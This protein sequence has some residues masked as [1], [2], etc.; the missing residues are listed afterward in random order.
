MKTFIQPGDIVTMTAPAAKSSGDGV[1]VG[2]LFG[3]AVADAANCAALQIKTGGVATL[4]RDSADTFAV[5]DRVY[6]EDGSSFV[7]ITATSNKLIGVAM[8]AKSAAA[9]NIQVRLN[10]SFTQ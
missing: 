6:W 3:V 2:S 5:G 10:G 9:G 8:E 4:T 7:T 1:L